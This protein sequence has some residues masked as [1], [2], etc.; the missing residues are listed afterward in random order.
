MQN[1]VPKPAA[2]WS[3]LLTLAAALVLQA[4]GGAD[5]ALEVQRQAPTWTSAMRAAAQASPS[6]LP[7]TEGRRASLAARGTISTDQL[8]DWAE[9]SY[10]DLFPK[11]STTQRLTAGGIAYTVRYY[12]GTG[13]YVG[14]TDDGGVWGYGPS[15]QQRPAQLRT[16]VEYT[17][18]VSPGLCDAAPVACKTEIITGFTGDPVMR[19]IKRRCRGRWRR[20]WRQRGRGRQRGQGAGRP[21]QGDPPGRWRGAR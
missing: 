1:Q 4:C 8:L 2:N 7:G 5:S 11:G 3:T 13:N 16:G 15:H 10:P 6:S 20:R 18:L 19:P 14:V 12:P 9:R 21:D 17:R